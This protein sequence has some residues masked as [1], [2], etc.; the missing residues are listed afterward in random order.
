MMELICKIPEELGWVTVGACAVLV[1]MVVFKIGALLV[2]EYR[3]AKAEEE[4]EEEGAE[5]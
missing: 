4:E 1:G 3:E 5:D 2:K